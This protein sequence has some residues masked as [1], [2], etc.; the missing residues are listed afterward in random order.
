MFDKHILE[1]VAERGRPQAARVKEMHLAVSKSA[2]DINRPSWLLTSVSQS[3]RSGRGIP[4][5]EW[6]IHTYTFLL[7]FPLLCK[8]D[9]G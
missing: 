8:E 2:A 5:P 3:N 6:E 7:L 4:K 9:G 1:M